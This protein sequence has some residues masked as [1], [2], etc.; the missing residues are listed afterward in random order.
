MLQV[1]GWFCCLQMRIEDLVAANLQTRLDI[2][3]PEEL[4]LALHDFVDKDEKAALANC[5]ATVLTE[6]QA[7]AVRMLKALILW[8]LTSCS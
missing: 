4:A 1:S 3:P 5:V 2:L 7:A 8:V 6:T